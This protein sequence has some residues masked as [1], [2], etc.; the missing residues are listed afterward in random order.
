MAIISWTVER[1]DLDWLTEK[2]IDKV[3]V[4]AAARTG[5]SEL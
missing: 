4:K 2:T 3:A 5:A 1:G